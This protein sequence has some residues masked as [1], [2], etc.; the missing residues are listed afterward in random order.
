MVSFF[1]Q[2]VN[3]RYHTN[4]SMTLRLVS[5][6]RAVHCYLLLII[7]ILLVI[8]GIYKLLDKKETNASFVPVTTELFHNLGLANVKTKRLFKLC[9]FPEEIYQ[10]DEGEYFVYYVLAVQRKA[11][12]FVYLV[13]LF[14]LYK[15]LK[16][17]C[18]RKE[19]S[20]N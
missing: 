1:A 4:I 12:L 17:S 20:E 8:A 7:W 19:N 2:F 14:F 15:F 11:P 10:G 9:N 13:D 16:I 6:N 3:E 18:K 5:Q